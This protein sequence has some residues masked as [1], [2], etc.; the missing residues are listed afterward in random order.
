MKVEVTLTVFFNVVTLLLSFFFISYLTKQLT[1]EDFGKYQLIVTYITLLGVFAFP[2]F[3]MLINKAVLRGKDY[4]FKALFLDSYK[5]TTLIFLS[6]TLILGILQYLFNNERL[7]LLF[8]AL[9]FLPLLGLEKYEPVLNAKQRFAK[10]R[11]LSLISLIFHIGLSLIFIQLT[12][13]YLYIF[14]SLFITKA[15]TVW[16]GLLY[17]NKSLIKEEVVYDYDSKDDLKEGYRLSLLTFYNVGIGHI[18]KLI[19][20]L[21]DY[22]LLAIYAIGI[23]IPMKVKDQLKLIVNIMTQSWAK[24]GEEYYKAQIK[25]LHNPVFIGLFIISFLMSYS[26]YLYIPILFT[27]EYLDSLSIVW[28]VAF[29]IPFILSGFTHET[30]I[31]VFHNTDF[32]QKVTYTK[33]AVYLLSLSILVPNLG[34]IGIAIS[35]LIRSVYD[36]FVNYFYYHKY[37]K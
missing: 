22:K 3:N 27:E 5:Y 29:T 34:I 23:L 25:K 33:Q 36:F 8:I 32:Y 2:S 18:D 20:G 13:Q 12:E 21:I 11:L 4:V 19:I 7:E 26:A 15:L 1:T 28:I 30:F 14:L 16:L 17:A 37:Y 10:I 35:I 24:N 31:I 6:L 9:F